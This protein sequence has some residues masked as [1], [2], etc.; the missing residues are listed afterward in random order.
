MPLAETCKVGCVTFVFG[1][2]KPVLARLEADTTVLNWEESSGAMHNR[3]T[4]LDL[5]VNIVAGDWTSEGVDTRRGAP[6]RTRDRRNI[7]CTA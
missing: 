6:N 4:V 3:D 5:V 1:T 2:R 7:S